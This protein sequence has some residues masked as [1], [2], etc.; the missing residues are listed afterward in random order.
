M[1]LMV[2]SSSPLRKEVLERLLGECLGETTLT[3][4]WDASVGPTLEALA[5]LKKPVVVITPHS[6]YYLEDLLEQNPQAILSEALGLEDLVAAIRLVTKG[7]TILPSPVHAEVLTASERKTLKLIALGHSNTRIAEQL[8]VGRST[9]AHRIWELKEKLQ[10]PE[11]EDLGRVYW[12][13]TN[14]SLASSHIF[15]A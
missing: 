9:I 12:G 2:I 3:I 6:G 10:V 13:M 5:E 11:R 14:N 15:M 8:Q 4:I 7:Q 1:G